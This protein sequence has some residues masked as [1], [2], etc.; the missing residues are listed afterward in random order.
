[1]LNEKT[2]ENASDK[3]TVDEVCKIVSEMSGIQLGEKQYSMVENRLKTRILKLSMDT[4]AE[5]LDYLKKH[6]ESESQALLSLMT[7]HHTFFFREFAHFEYLLNQVLPQAVEIARARSDKTIQLWSAACSRG[8]EVYSLAMFMTFHLKHLAPDVKF[9][10]WG[11][12]IDPESVE[13]AKQGVYKSEEIK[14]SPAMYVDGHWVR[15]HGSAYGFV[16]A[17]DHLKANCSFTT[18]NLQSPGSFLNGKKFDIIFCRNVFIYFNQEQIKTITK[19]LLNHMHDTGYLI[20]GVSET[21]QGFGLDVNLKGASVYQHKKAPV[22]K[23]AAMAVTTPVLPKVMNVL[24]IDDSKTILALMKKILIPENGFKVVATADN[25]LQGLEEMKKHKIDVI[26]LDLHM[27]ELD[28]VGFLLKKGHE[29]PAVLVVSSI[30]RD[31]VTIAQKAIQAGAADYVEKPSLENLAQAG[32]E[33]RSKLKTIWQQKNKTTDAIAPLP[34]KESMPKV[35]ISTNS[36]PIKPVTTLTKSS[37]Q[38]ASTSRFAVSKDKR[39]LKVL[40]VD[41]SVTMCQILEKVISSDPALEVVAMTGKPSEVET[42]IKKHKPD[43]M[44]FD[45]NMPEMTGVDLVKK[46]HP[47]YKIPTIMISSLSS[48]DGPLVMQALENGAIDYIQKPEKSNLPEVSLLI[49][50]R[51]KTAAG[52]KVLTRANKRKVNRK[53]T[54]SDDQLILMGSSTGGTE[55]LRVILESLPNEIP[56]ILIVQHI[57]AFFSEAFAKRIDSLVNFEV[58]EARDGDEVK[59]NCVLIAPGGMQMGVKMVGDKMKVVVNDD[60]QVNRHKPSVDYL[61]QSVNRIK[62]T[63]LISVILTGM[64]S[65]GARQMKVLRDAGSRTI[66]QDEATCVV[67]G[68]PREAIRMGGAEF[69][70]PIQGIAEKIVDLINENSN[71]KVKKAG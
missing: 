27:P 48:E 46:L 67:F 36:T 62:S 49:C 32:N 53:A 28:G 34:T 18:A 4:F 15:G 21:L 10:I 22:L 56:P 30:N 6:K 25:G 37:T 29:G 5:Y 54:A 26:T 23:P 24:C 50:E 45:I 11:T 9:H 60:P 69:I 31:D 20:L 39:K 33:I 42:L 14:Q 66:A 58:K 2:A 41:D 17:K 70:L 51:I 63:G 57:P 19:N 61:F 16:K 71:G 12:D 47:V 38:V 65:D 44:T 7:T 68:M 3:A 55:A 13:R 40:V 52:A 59:K 64:G 43:V 1:V 35:S 8:Q